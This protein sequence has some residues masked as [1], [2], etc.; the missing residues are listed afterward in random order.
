LL[1]FTILLN[2][3]TSLSDFVG[4]LESENPLTGSFLEP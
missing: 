1:V 2:I 3:V 4:L